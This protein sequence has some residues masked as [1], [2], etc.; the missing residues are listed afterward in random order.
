VSGRRPIGIFDSGLGGLSVLRELV[1]VLPNE[2]VVYVADSAHVPYGPKPPAFIRARSLT[3]TKFLVGVHNAKAVVVACNTATTHAVEMLRREFPDVPIVGM[4]PAIKPAA[5]ATRSGTVGVLATQATLGGERFVDLAQRYSEG[6]ELLTQPS[7]GL[8]ECVEAG[9][10]NGPEAERL[11]RAYTE[12]MLARG[13][14]TIV[15][16]CTHYPF[17]RDRLQGI[18]GNDVQIIDTGEAVA[19]Q[20]VR[21][22]ERVERLEPSERL[23]QPATITYYS[24]GD[25]NTARAVIQTLMQQPVD[26]VLPLPFP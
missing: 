22:L 24:S 19:R 9:D 13:A 3:I 10:V 18:V 17:L 26:R 6:I 8:V 14:D 7:P 16:G 20:T 5:A 15:L 2:D 25:V 12:P 11:L 23:E 4:E 1:R 21:V